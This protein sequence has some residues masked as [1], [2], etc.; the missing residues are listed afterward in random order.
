MLRYD[1]S[2]VDTSDTDTDPDTYT[3]TNFSHFGNGDTPD[4][5]TIYFC[6]ESG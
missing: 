5:P 1:Q 2:L 6:S 4:K 3:F